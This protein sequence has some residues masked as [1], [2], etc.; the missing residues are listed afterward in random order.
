MQRLI[1]ANWKMNFSLPEA[2]ALAQAIARVA[3]ELPATI[4]IA[5]SFPWIIPIK[6]S[7][8][9]QPKNLALASQSVSPWREGAYTGGV[10]A[11]QLQHLVDYSL[12]GHSERRV[13]CHETHG[14]VADQLMRLHEVGIRPILCFG[15]TRK[16]EQS[17]LLEQLMHALSQDLKGMPDAL[18]DQVIL[19][20]EPLWAIGTGKSAQPDYIARVVAHTKAWSKAT[21]GKEPPVLY[22]GSVDEDNARELG[23][24]K[25]LDGL[26]VGGASLNIKRFQVV[27]RQFL[28]H[29]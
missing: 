22:G 4:V 10:S 5:P 26:L 6:E 24:V 1:V 9:W 11:K 7:L 27:C 13:H 16:S 8:R 3:E 25:N 17:A 20:Y 18:I 2:T 19:A 29:V 14:I 12:V 23:Q 21:M 28:T 15:E